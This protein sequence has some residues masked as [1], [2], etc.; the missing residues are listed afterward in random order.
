MQ[1]VWYS[2]ALSAKKLIVHTGTCKKGKATLQQIF[3]CLLFFSSARCLQE[4][5]KS[6]HTHR[7]WHGKATQGWAALAVCKIFVTESID[8][9]GEKPPSLMRFPFLHSPQGLYSLIVRA[10]GTS[11]T[12]AHFIKCHFG[13]NFTLWPTLARQRKQN[14]RCSLRLL[15]QQ[16]FIHCSKKLP[17]IHS[18]PSTPSLLCPVTGQSAGL[19]SAHFWCLPIISQPSLL[20]S[21]FLLPKPA[22]IWTLNGRPPWQQ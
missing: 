9:R 21:P 11:S 8:K 17:G 16:R 1:L 13:P 3:S 20:L 22:G 14:A 4:N 5:T 6:T 10:Q 7:A 15:P 18:K 12:R 19:S 2:L